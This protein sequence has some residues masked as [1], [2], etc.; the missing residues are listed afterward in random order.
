MKIL[1]T[2]ASGFIGTNLV[3]A[4]LRANLGSV[5]NLDI[6]PPLN[7]EHLPYW[8]HCDV[9]SF[10][11]LNRV[12]SDFL[13]DA[14]IHLAA[15]TDTSS[16]DVT[17]YSVNYLGTANLLRCLNHEMFSDVIFV[18]ASTQYVYKSLTS[19]LPPDQYTF[20]P[21]TAYG[22]S[23]CFAEMLLTSSNSYFS[24]S[25]VRPTN[26]WG[27]WNYRYME[28]LFKVMKAGIY[29]HPINRHP[30]KS[31]G[32]V[33]NVCHQILQILVADR[34][35][36]DQQVFYVGD[37]PISS[38]SWLTSLS[39][40][41][42]NG[43]IIHVPYILLA[44]LAKFGD[45]LLFFNIHVPLYSQRL[46]NMIDD[47]PVPMDKTLSVLGL[48]CPDLAKNVTTTMDWCRRHGF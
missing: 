10:D 15:R 14:V 31:Y 42:N 7:K 34:Q 41:I 46:N 9:R 43:K 12:V 19:P 30:T 21:H 4:I 29:I 35:L 44:L 22:L 2:G 38:K 23:K 28:S 16:P 33:G 20:S 45:I 36:V 47:Y 8:L 32:Y 13:P 6:S 37:P 26:V 3:D 48:P 17:D 27:P 40:A 11:S 1:I 25:I 24:W 18:L 39:R 5:L